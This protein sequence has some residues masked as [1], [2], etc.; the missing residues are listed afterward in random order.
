MTKSKKQNKQPVTIRL[1]S[2]TVDALKVKA[3]NGK[4]S[5]AEIIQH[6]LDTVF[7]GKSS[8]QLE[9]RLKS[10]IT[11][12]DETKKQYEQLAKKTGK[13][14]SRTKKISIPLSREEHKVLK[15]KATELDVSMGEIVRNVLFASKQPQLE[16]TSQ[17]QRKKTPML[18]QA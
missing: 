14:V 7:S 15:I 10:T 6:A 9:A 2:N 8:E 18:I 11:E 5:Q 13:K 17:Q 1:D 3:D 16:S 12:L 4:L